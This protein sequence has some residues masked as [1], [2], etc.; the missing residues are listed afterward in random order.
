MAKMRKVSQLQTIPKGT[1]L[2]TKAPR[3][4]F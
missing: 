4:F 1:N 2:P 3:R